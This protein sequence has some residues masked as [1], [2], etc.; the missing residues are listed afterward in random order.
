MIIRRIKLHNIRSYADA[1][2]EFP[3]GTI[4]F[5]GDIGSG[6]STILMAIEFALFGTSEREFYG[7]LLRK[8]TSKGW[9]EV[10]FEHDGESYVVYRS[11][12]KGRGENIKSGEAY[13]VTPQGK[14]YLSPLEIKSQ[15]L[16]LLGVSVTSEKKKKTL[17]IVKYAIYT[18][19]EMMKEI[20]MGNPEERKK[21][22]RRIFK[23]DEYEV[24]RNNTQIILTNIRSE[25]RAM[26]K[27]KEDYEK[28]VRHLEEINEKIGLMM[29]E[30]QKKAR[31]KR[32]KER[33]YRT[34]YENFEREKEKRKKYEQL[35]REIER[36]ETEIRKEEEET[37]KE[38]TEL[39]ELKK[40]ED[41][42]RKIEKDAKRY[43]ELKIEIDALQE[44]MERMH[45][46]ERRKSNLE[47]ELKDV[48]EQKVRLERLRKQ[49][50]KLSQDIERL[51]ESLKKE[52]LERKKVEIEERRGALERSLGINEMKLRELKRDLEDLGKLGARC[53]KCKQPISEEYKRRLIDELEGE[54]KKREENL[55]HIREKMEDIRREMEEIENALREEREKEKKIA[56]MEGERVKAEEEIK[57]IEEKMM[58][59]ENLKEELKKIDDELEKYREL[60]RKYREVQMKIKDLEGIWKE[61]NTLLGRVKER[62]RLEKSIEERERNIKER[63]NA[64]LLKREELE[65]LKYREEDY[66]KAERAYTEAYGELKKLRADLENIERNLEEWM[67]E[68]KNL[69]DD[70]HN[71]E[72]EIEKGEKLKDIEAWLKDKFISALE[73]IEKRRMALINEEFRALFESWFQELLGESEYEATIDENFEPRITYEKYDMPIGSLSGGERTSVALAYRLSLNTMVKRS[74]GL[75]T[76]LLILDEP[77]DGFSKDQLYKL[78]DIFD[79]MD[80]DQIIIVTH[81]KELINIADVVY[82]V[83]KVGG[84]SRIILRQAQ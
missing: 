49:V 40:M 82:H 63:K 2:I 5:E 59:G 46:L 19:Q 44:K 27:R 28:S 42:V 24:A 41:R 21:V 12:E 38:R 58:R 64:L 52:E 9:V 30:R 54:V 29:E 68:R 1:D 11:L 39:E 6:K 70:I 50:E 69:E 37:K 73:S 47:G 34:L 18:P 48:E 77:T 20:L 35:R 23:I 45:Y 10:E 83:E 43:E 22:I 16:G 76:N 14:R 78:K 74:L 53:P 80:T 84:K 55:R 66:I 75:K 79:K 65:S 81:E 4:L 25:I 60:E 62:D 36:M 8:G 15:V 72:K 31:M 17:P 3:K 13:I 51:R 56:R 71:L 67:R 33:E 61:Y 26:E 57:R 32:E 7:K